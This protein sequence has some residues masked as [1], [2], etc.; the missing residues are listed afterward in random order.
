LNTSFGN[1]QLLKGPFGKRLQLNQPLSR[2]TA[3]RIGG[4]ADGLFEAFSA[5]ELAEVVTICWQEERP[6]YVLGSGSNV[7]VSDKGVRGLVLINRARDIKFITEEEPILVWAESGANLGVLARLA[8]SKGLAGLEWAAGIPGTLG[9]AIVGNAG[10]HGS[11]MAANLH[12]AEIL[13][14]N[15][16]QK[17]VEG[18]RERWEAGDFNFAYRSSVIKNS[19]N[20][21]VVLSASLL[22]ML[23]NAKT[24]QAR[25]DELAMYRKRTQP[26]GA[27]MGSMFK[28]PSGDFAGR[29]IDAVGLKGMRSGGAQ[30]SPLHA[31]FFINAE[32][33]TAADVYDLICLARKRVEAEF[34]INLELEVELIGE[35]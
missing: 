31:N 29:L 2:F 17:P 35:W 16:L 4:P 11:D 12:L 8:A 6:L 21:S 33:A 23:S 28:N 5:E 22:L 1:S 15:N 10:A 26:P 32:D 9:G 27:S 13:H 24:V 34:G 25:I 7:L 18:V 30:I 19:A 20:K 3:S 14:H